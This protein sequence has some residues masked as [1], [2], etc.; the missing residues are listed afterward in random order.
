MG[1]LILCLLVWVSESLY[2]EEKLSN[3]S[4]R[5]STKNNF[6]SD[7]KDRTDG[8]VLNADVT[9]ERN[10]TETLCRTN[11]DPEMKREYPVIVFNLKKKYDDNFAVNDLC[12]KVKTGECF[13]LLGTNGAGKTS[14]LQMM[15]LNMAVTDGVIYLNNVNIKNN[16]NEYKRSF[17]YCPQ[18][19]ALNKSM[20]AYETLKYLA[21]IKGV[22]DV[23]AETKKWLYKCDLENYAN[24]SVMNYSGGTK[25]KL[26]TAIA[27][28]GSP[29]VIFLDEPTTGIDPV[30]RRKIWKCIKDLKNEGKTI[31]LTSHSL[32]ECEHLCNRI[33]I[34]YNGN[35][36]CIGVTQKLKNDFGDGYTLII[37]LTEDVGNT[38]VRDINTELRNLQFVRCEEDVMRLDKERQLLFE[39]AVYGMEMEMRKLGLDWKNKD[40]H[41]QIV[42][43]RINRKEIIWSEV[44]EI[45]TELRSKCSA[46][47]SDYSV[48]EVSLEDIFLQIGQPRL[49][50]N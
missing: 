14:T 35:M 4:C 49:L 30:S 29:K 42:K 9:T 1:A 27:M 24:V 23:E 45:L 17:G 20:T 47:I 5:N 15:T 32:D 33:G 19:D 2:W 18:I 37:K 7:S 28:I 22:I 43:Y 25:R 6:K 10:E 26:N 16:E 31:I 21:L 50:E 13:G 8:D 39:Q 3:F 11:S 36:H 12:F 46:E 48:N 41:G 34:M 44:F 38:R 40:Q